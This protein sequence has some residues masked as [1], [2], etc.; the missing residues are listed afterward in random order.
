MLYN[1]CI[2]FKNGIG[3]SDNNYKCQSEKEKSSA[4][5]CRELGTHNLT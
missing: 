3:E 2:D 5:Y 1:Y 4:L